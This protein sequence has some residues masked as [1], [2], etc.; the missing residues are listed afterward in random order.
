MGGAPAGSGWGGAGILPAGLESAGGIGGLLAVEDA[1]G[2]PATTSDDLS[3]VFCYD[4]NGNVGQV[5][6]LSAPTAA[7]SLAARYEYDP[8]G[9]ITGPDTDAD[10]DWRDDAGSYA[11]TNAWRFST[12]QWDDETGLG[13]WGYRYYSARLG[14]WVS[15][16]PIGERGGYGLYVHATN[17]PAGRVDGLGLLPCPAQRAGQPVPQPNCESM[18]ADAK[19]DKHIRALLAWLE[20]PKNKCPKPNL[21]CGTPDECRGRGGASNLAD[22]TI[23][24]CTSGGPQLPFTL[25]I[26]HELIHS[27]QRCSGTGGGAGPPGKPDEGTLDTQPCREIQANWCSAQARPSAGTPLAPPPRGYIDNAVSFCVDSMRTYCNARP[28]QCRNLQG[29]ELERAIA[30]ACRDAAND[31]R[32]RDCTSIPGGPRVE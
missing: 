3:Y 25:L 30:T 23:L 29:D 4:A 22:G 8:Y 12:K 17:S 27:W 13:Y 2:T 11:S 7:A 31:P 6:D 24:V 20:D 1:N 15:R 5:V 28:D 10:G 26:H 21:R 18:L 9:Q 14:R 16:D 19:K 32:C